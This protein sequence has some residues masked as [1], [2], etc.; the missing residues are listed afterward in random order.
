MYMKYFADDGREFDNEEECEQYEYAMKMKGKF[1]TTR[2]FNRD[3]KVVPF[4]ASS[5]FCE[6]LFY[7]EVNNMDEALLLHNWFQDYGFESPWSP[8]RFRDGTNITTGRFFYDSDIDKWRNIE[9]L[10]MAYQ[11]VLDIFESG[12]E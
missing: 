4:L 8:K 10:Y 2:F 7:I 3:G 1:L 11:D 6:N 5:E 9:E 12:G